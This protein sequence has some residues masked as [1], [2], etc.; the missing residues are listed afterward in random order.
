[1]NEKYDLM[2]RDFLKKA[3]IAGMLA[4]MPSIG[5]AGLSAGNKVSSAPRVSLKEGAV[6]L[7]QG[8]SIT[9]AGRDKDATSANNGNALGR[10][11]AYLAACELLYQYPGKNLSVYNKGIS[12]N[13]VYQLAERWE[14][15]C[16][17][18]KPDVL[19]ILIGVN[20]YWHKHNGKYDGTVKVYRDDYRAL[21]N[22]TLEQL[23]DVQLVIGEPFAVK[24]VKAV[25]D[26]WY[27]EFDE[28]RAA[29]RE[30]AEEFKAAFIPYQSIFDKAEKSAAGAYWTPDGVHP[31]LAGANLMAHAWMEA[32]GK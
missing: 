11:Y 18:L 24:D 13:K 28:Y 29:A 12:G 21:L 23:P 10:G 4:A 31:S 22:R 5:R 9:D 2:R 15:D 7:F 3:S 32:V 26:S 16:L 8:D 30:I 19:S 17:S 27:P 6:V 14:V 25:D 20:D 1:M